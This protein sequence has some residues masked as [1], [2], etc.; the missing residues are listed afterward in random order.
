[1]K[2]DP[3]VFDELAAT[4]RE[5]RRALHRRLHRGNGR[6]VVCDVVG[7]TEEILGTARLLK[8]FNTAPDVEAAVASFE[9]G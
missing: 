3:A 7:N 1:M 9:A 2:P 5:T 8:Y 6:L 4:A